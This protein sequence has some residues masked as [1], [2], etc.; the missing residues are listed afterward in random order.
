MFV[1]VISVGNGG[2]IINTGTVSMNGS[3]YITIAGPTVIISGSTL[4]VNSYTTIGSTLAVSNANINEIS[5][6][7]SIMSNVLNVVVGIT[8]GFSLTDGN[9]SIANYLKSQLSMCFVDRLFLHGERVHRY[10]NGRND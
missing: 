8:N 10:G 1:D 4:T 9:G 3:A 6:L 5:G 7:T 2:V